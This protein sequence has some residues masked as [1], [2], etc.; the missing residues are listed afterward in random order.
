MPKKVQKDFLEVSQHNQSQLLK[1]IDRLLEAQPQVQKAQRVSE[2]RIAVTDSHGVQSEADS[3]V[4]HSRPERSAV[5]DAGLS[6]ALESSFV[7]EGFVE[8][9][10]AIGDEATLQES[11]RMC[12]EMACE[13]PNAIA[14]LEAVKDSQSSASADST[15]IS[16][17]EFF[18]MWEEKEG[19]ED[20]LKQVRHEL[21]AAQRQG[22]Y[23]K[24]RISSLDAW[25]E[26]G[27]APVVS[28]LREDFTSVIEHAN[29]LEFIDFT[30]NADHALDLDES[31]EGPAAANSA[32][33]A[34][35]ALND[36]AQA[37]DDG[38]FTNGGIREYMKN[39]PEGCDTISSHK[40]AASES[41]QVKCNPR[42]TQAR[43]FPMPNGEEALMLMHVKLG[44]GSLAPRMHLFDDTANSGKIVVGYIGRHLPSNLS[45]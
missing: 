18:A 3:E 19:L 36:Y 27:Q 15:S 13:Y 34:L 2:N 39:P 43:T 22:R 35:E 29:E 45:T 37:K 44:Q 41:E 23:W 11:L 42:F 14:M 24:I 38:R 33:A 28:D 30:G 17:D 4:A 26:V 32:H 7:G 25:K 12:I 6:A 31:Q 20:E 9:V 10:Q 40:F 16:E 5:V 21:L 1:E 8:R